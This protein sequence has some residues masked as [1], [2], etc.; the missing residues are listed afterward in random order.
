MLVTLGFLLPLPLTYAATSIIYPSDPSIEF[1]PGWSQ[2]YSQTTQDLYMQTDVFP[3]SLTATLP[4]SA[5]S[6]SFVGY[7]RNGWSLYGYCLDCVGAEDELLKAANGT[8][9]SVIDTSLALES[10]L[11]TVAMD[12]STEH[13]LTVY[14][15]P[16]DQLG[17]SGE[18]TFDHLYVLV[19]DNDSA[20]Q[21]GRFQGATPGAIS[22][23][24]SSTPL[25]QSTSSSAAVAG[26]STGTAFSTASLNQSTASGMIPVLQHPTSSPSGTADPVAASSGPATSRTGISKS[27]VASMSILAVILVGFAIACLVVFL[28]QR[29]QRRRVGAQSSHTGNRSPTGSIIPIMPPPLQM[30]IASANPFSD[31]PSLTGAALPLDDPSKN[32]LVQRRMENRSI[33]PGSAPTI[34]LPDLP[35]DRSMNRLESRPNTP[36]S[37]FA[38]NDL[39][40]ARPVQTP[41]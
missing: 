7:K 9:P 23:A 5:S 25:S 1:S 41:V 22:G 20:P 35:P 40:I 8:D 13:T 28:R 30:R 14:N 4:I 27:L 15:L 26:L 19:A 16:N 29:R 3:A 11:F 18:I 6:V 36:N 2:E 12:P 32:S 21:S 10:T 37:A 24:A 39:W 31:P 38:R 17:G 33:S 34:P